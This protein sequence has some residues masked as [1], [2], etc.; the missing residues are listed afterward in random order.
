MNLIKEI[1]I[2]T[3]NDSPAIA[4]VLGEQAMMSLSSVSDRLEDSISC[5]LQT[6]ADRL[7][8][9]QYTSDASVPCCEKGRSSRRVAENERGMSPCHHMGV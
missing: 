4:T 9:A 6:Y 5:E 7:P 8:K 3:M 2:I 1:I